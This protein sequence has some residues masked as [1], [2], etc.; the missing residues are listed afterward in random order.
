MPIIRPVTELQRKLGE[1]TKLA[2]E[3][4]EPVFLTKNGAAH[5]VLLDYDLYAKLEQKAKQ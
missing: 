1:V 4:G 5:L 3:S 2:K